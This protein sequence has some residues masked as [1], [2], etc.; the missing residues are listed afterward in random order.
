MQYIQILVSLLTTDSDTRTT[1]LPR[2]TFTE[3]RKRNYNHQHWKHSQFK[4]QV[5]DL[6]CNPIH[7]L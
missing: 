6:L 7:W 5:R 2:K 1:Q 4:C 3:V